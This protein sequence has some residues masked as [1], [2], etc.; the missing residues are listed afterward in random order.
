MVP[1]TAYSPKGK[2]CTAIPNVADVACESGQC[3]IRHCL[4]GLVPSAD[5]NSCV[6][7]SEHEDS[8]HRH[9]HGAIEDDDSAKAYG[10]E[11]VPLRRD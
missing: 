1:L 10:L 9:P 4:D 5:G 2:D 11:H 3:V 8:H 7:E 6:S